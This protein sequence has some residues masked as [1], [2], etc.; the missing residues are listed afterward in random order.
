[1]LEEPLACLGRPPA[2]PGGLC[3]DRPAMAAGELRVLDELG[4][5][6][7]L[8]PLEGLVWRAYFRLR[9]LRR[10]LCR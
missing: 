1:M 3:G 7:R 10:S 4:R 5:A 8:L 9:Q 6:G 2:T